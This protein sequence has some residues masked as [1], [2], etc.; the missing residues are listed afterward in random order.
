MKN[1][2][3]FGTSGIRGVVGEDIT[4]TLCR[5]V[6]RATATT[7]PTQ[8][9]VC[10]A[11]DT[12]LSREILRD[13]V[14]SGF[15]S[16]NINV[17]DLGVLP[18]PALAFITREMDFSTGIMITASHNPP[19]YNG[20]KLF[21]G[22]GIG[23]SQAQ[24]AEIEN[25]YLEKRFR[26]GGTAVLSKNYS[27]KERYFQFI[28]NRFSNNDFEL[29]IVVDAANG[30][31][32]GFA[33]SLFSLAGLDVI[34]L[35]DEPNGNF[36]GRNPEPG[37]DTLGA[38][39]EF[40]RRHNADLAVCFDGDADRV[41][42]CDREGF[43]GFNEMIA[44]ISRIAIKETGKKRLAATIDTGKL[45]DMAVKDLGAKVVRGKVGD[46]SVAHLAQKINAAIG[47]EPAG[48]YIIPEAGYYPDSMYAALT[49]LS[50]IRDISQ[51]RDFFK[52]MPRLFFGK[53]KIT[54]TDHLKAAIMQEVYPI[55]C[56][57]GASEINTLDGLRLE[58]DDSWLLIRASGTE[59]VIRVIAEST[60]KTET[61]TL[62]SKGAEVVAG[63]LKE[64]KDKN[65]ALSVRA[66]IS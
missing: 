22:N 40:L 26:V 43:L 13:A 57:L 47:I 42:F 38:T 1:G 3:L 23:Y 7:L 32:S 61:E 15:L 31:A 9:Q 49:L 53:R 59:P 44:L 46:V 65:A 8:S 34:P 58:F 28:L 62:L 25:I 33:S 27:T 24:E 6:A 17:T 20:I 54:C 16:S 64:F 41:V 5:N 39:I 2:H 56:S 55:A 45:V 60:S 51:I 4:T 10:L 48:V 11:T 36:P 35:N 18:T 50:Q 37:Q 52:G 12:R 21:N 66:W 30:A 19:E 29:K 14:I 63:A